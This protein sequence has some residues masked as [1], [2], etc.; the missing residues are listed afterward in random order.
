[1]QAGGRQI[2]ADRG[3]QLL[4]LG[5]REGQAA[6]ALKQLDQGLEIPL[7]L[8]LQSTQS[9]PTG[10]ERIEGVSHRGARAG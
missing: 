7:P 9:P 10:L 1:M 5:R 6:V 3:Q 4:P 2:G 8:P